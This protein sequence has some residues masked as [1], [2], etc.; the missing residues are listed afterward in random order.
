MAAK[1]LERKE[2]MP[3]LDEA[4]QRFLQVERRPG[5]NRQ[6][7]HITRHFKEAMGA[8][9]DIAS[10]DYPALVSYIALLRQRRHRGKPLKDA[11]VREYA[12]VVRS[13]FSWCMD[14]GYI[15]HS[16]AI[17]LKVQKLSPAYD[18]S[19]A[20]PP[21]E[22][23]RMI[24]YARATSLRNYAMMMFLTDTG[25]RVGGAVSLTLTNLHLGGQTADLIEKGG[26]EQRVYFGETTAAALAAWLEKR[27]TVNHDYVWTGDGPF[28]MPL[29]RAGVAAVVNRLADRTGASRRWGP[30]SIRHAVGHAWAKKGIPIVAIQ[31]KLGHSDPSVTM[32][33]YQ[34]KDANY[35]Q[36]LSNDLSLAALGESPAPLPVPKPTKTDGKIIRP[37]FG[38]K[39]S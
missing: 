1:R 4:I 17:K 8:E 15:Q 6:Y 34:P 38:K 11:T 18:Q 23:T 39:T 24:E 13:L 21:D 20:I 37:D 29:T 35:L 14:A 36:R 19:R 7:G 10:I 33:F 2:I 26:K 12:Q 5:T 31:M 28:Y 3:T 9:C 25:C 32:R 16:P 22:L 27:P 30:H